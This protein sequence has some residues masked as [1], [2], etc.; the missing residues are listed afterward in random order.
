M[1][2]TANS[3]IVIL[4]A[5]CLYAFCFEP[6]QA[7]YIYAKED[8]SITSL[9]ITGGYTETQGIKLDSGRFINLSGGELHVLGS[10]D[11]N[12]LLEK[13]SH[14]KI[15]GHGLFVLH[16]EDKL[17][18]ISKLIQDGIITWVSDSVNRP[19]EVWQ[20]SWENSTKDRL[21]ANVENGSVNLW[22]G[23]TTLQE[24]YSALRHR[25]SFDFDASDG[26][27]T[28]DLKLKGRSRVSD[29][30]LF[31][32]GDPNN[33]S[34]AY[35]DGSALT[36]IASTINSAKGVTFEAWVLV[37]AN[38]M[39]RLFCVGANS[40][41]NLELIVQPNAQT[42]PIAYINCPDVKGANIGST[43]GAIPNGELCYI[44]VVYDDI[45]NMMSIHVASANGKVV[46]TR[47]YIRGG[48]SFDNTVD[49]LTPIFSD[50]SIDKFRL[51][52]TFADTRI[53]DLKGVIDE[54]R[55]WSTALTDEQIRCNVAA[56]PDIIGVTFGKVTIDITKAAYP[57]YF[58]KL[59]TKNFVDLAPGPTDVFEAQ[60]KYGVPLYFSW[61]TEG[62]DDFRKLSARHLGNAPYD[63]TNPVGLFYRKN[64]V[65]GVN[66]DKN[67]AEVRKNIH[68][69]GL[70]NYVQWT[71]FPYYGHK[72]PAEWFYVHDPMH[73][74]TS[75]AGV[76]APGE[77]QKFAEDLALLAATNAE[78]DR[79]LY[80]V[81]RPAIWSHLQE[82]E[83][84]YGDKNVAW[85]STAGL[86]LNRN[87][88]MYNIRLCATDIYTPFTKR[89]H[90]LEP[91]IRV[92][93]IASNA[94]VVADQG[95]NE[96][97]KYGPVGGTAHGVM[98]KA[99]IGKEIANKEEYPLDYLTMNCYKGYNIPQAYIPQSRFALKN[100]I[101]ELFPSNPEKF[102]RF[103]RTYY[104]IS[105]YNFANLGGF[106][107]AIR[108]LYYNNDKG[109]N[110]ALLENISE[111]LRAPDI[112]YAT[113]LGELTGANNRTNLFTIAYNALPETG[114]K[115]ET[116]VG[117]DGFAAYD[118]S[119]GFYA[120]FTNRNDYAVTAPIELKGMDF[121]NALF[122]VVQPAQNNS[123][124][125]QLKGVELVEKNVWNVPFAGNDIVF[126]AASNKPFPSALLGS[127]G[128]EGLFNLHLKSKIKR[129]QFAASD[130]YIPR[131]NKMVLSEWGFLV[132]PEPASCAYFDQQ[133]GRMEMGLR[134][135]GVTAC[136]AVVL[137]HLPDSAYS[138]KGRL[139]G[140]G[141]PANLPSNA[142][143]RIRVDYL[144]HN[145]VL[146]SHEIKDAGGS[147]SATFDDIEW[148]PG[149]ESVSQTTL[150]MWSNRK[151]ALPIGDWQP[152]TWATS[153]DGKRR[154]RIS[155]MLS[156]L[157]NGASLMID[158]DDTI[159]E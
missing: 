47:E 115:I 34:N 84:N 87:E 75:K 139:S 81:F 124:W 58:K 33:G 6:V 62:R 32:A 16:G 126:M 36:E 78:Y 5:L 37:D 51:G 158:F 95:M 156:G 103:N 10:S 130:A 127:A 85:N 114:V 117:V 145:N 17:P 129:A 106:P 82:P 35:A 68:E 152:A 12:L 90:E 128:P 144:D 94:T 135:S 42:S 66:Y 159:V 120:V 118:D 2:K 153:D 91:D 112:A 99:W 53:D 86:N 15:S 4:F 137:R 83:H 93:G 102:N 150:N 11:D 123:K 9:N 116:K 18:I 57:V 141:L 157:E 71:N 111:I 147:G 26:V 24:E 50:L 131:E 70:I 69:A 148:L 67:W 41:N 72:D 154:I 108:N 132:P 3:T 65:V 105:D 28:A 77:R 14:I 38:Y 109:R 21:Y 45:R 96:V 100:L 140:I 22:A 23:Q 25:Y 143:F 49:D 92:A 27:G 73:G 31:L 55:I 76:P 79:R 122:W 97:T 63:P 61:I 20:R 136:A 64:G 101:H 98:T 119:L 8:S 59:N 46:T 151:F 104:F 110:A 52:S 30:N 142:T 125:E 56:G 7:E 74:P 54:F 13:G 146:A 113:V 48:G 155:V 134:D 121:N 39:A 138:I 43:F 80:G 60:G 29:G 89:L 19:F 40:N 107:L 88:K 1:R 133:K 149:A 44:A